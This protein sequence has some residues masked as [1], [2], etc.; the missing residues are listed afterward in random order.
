MASG[1]WYYSRALACCDSSFA[2]DCESAQ[3]LLQRRVLQEPS[4][5]ANNIPARPVRGNI[6]NFWA[7]S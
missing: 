3:R 4:M 7:H 1:L 2:C 6:R 5:P